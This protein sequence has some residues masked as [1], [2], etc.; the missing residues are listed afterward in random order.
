MKDLKGVWDTINAADCGC[1]QLIP[2]LV[3]KFRERKQ[4]FPIPQRFIF[5]TTENAGQI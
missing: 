1:S 5:L 4:H 2:V 3:W